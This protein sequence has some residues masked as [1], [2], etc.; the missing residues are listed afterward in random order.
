MLDRT[1]RRTTVE[2]APAAGKELPPRRRL[3]RAVAQVA[4][5][6]LVLAGAWVAMERLAAS[7]VERTPRSFTPAVYTV[8]MT[9]VERADN[10]PVIR[11]YG[12]VTAGRTVDLR[13]AV[14]G[15]VVEIHPDLAAGRPVEKG[16]VLVRIDPFAYEGALVEARANL[17]SVEG[18]IAEIDAR[19]ASER[20]QLEAV[21]EQLQFAQADLDR[22]LALSRSG[23]L[24]AQ[25]VDTRRLVLSQ[26]Q[27][28]AS[29][30]RNNIRIAEAQR[31][32]QEANAERLGW[33]V[34]EA[35]R[36]LEQTAVIAPFDGIVAE[37]QVETGGS[38]S[39]NEVVA[40]IYDDRALEVQFTLTNAQYGRMATDADPLVGRKAE[41]TW[42]VGGTDYVWPAVIDRTGA[43]VTAE[44]GGVEVHARIGEAQNPVR[45]RPGAFVALTVPDRNWPDTIRLP[46]TAVRGSDH[47]FAVVDGE[48]ARR[49]IRL[50]AWDGEDAIIDG[51]LAD[52]E[53]VLVT[54]LTEASDGVK[55]REPSGAMPAAAAENPASADAAPADP[56]SPDPAQ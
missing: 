55:V 6:A 33:K 42:T 13:A 50:I 11:L 19:L 21:T 28:A 7:R 12:Q 25:E 4:L 16:A 22:A 48:L 30:A 1:D 26:R 34:R 8:D 52:G 31:A 41:L 43:R 54:R 27:Q 45:L 46:E 44:R 37:E 20:E 2:D 23:T 47:V 36:K 24:T 51:D 10:R 49:D 17:A 53:R 14:G 15:D 3:P 39:A 35:E 18:A 29:Q 38:V 32:Q 5:M 40:S 9:T 56:A